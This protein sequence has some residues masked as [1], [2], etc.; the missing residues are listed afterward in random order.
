LEKSGLLEKIICT[1][2]HPRAQALAD[3]RFLDTLSVAGI[4]AAHLSG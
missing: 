2:T 4:L 1:D 3:Q